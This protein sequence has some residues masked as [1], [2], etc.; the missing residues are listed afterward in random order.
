MDCKQTANVD[1]EKTA[2]PTADSCYCAVEFLWNN[3][4]NLCGKD[5]TADENADGDVG[6]T[7]SICS[8]K[9]SYRWSEGSLSCV[10][11]C[12]SI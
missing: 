5:C 2:G 7:A 3:E 9:S 4:Q 10:V 12:D 6:P 11:G 8:C 1:T